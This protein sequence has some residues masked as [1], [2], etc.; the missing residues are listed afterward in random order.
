MRNFSYSLCKQLIPRRSPS[1]AG[2]ITGIVKLRAH[3][4]YYNVL[5]YPCVSFDFRFSLFRMMY[6]ET[7]WCRA[8]P[9]SHTR[10]IAWARSA[11][12]GSRTIRTFSTRRQPHVSADREQASRNTRGVVDCVYMSVY[13]ALSSTFSAPASRIGSIRQLVFWVVPAENINASLYY[14]TDKEIDKGF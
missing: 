1:F 12:L 4:Q 9:H 6:Y 7:S 2:N 8:V 10:S 3:A 11:S 14:L 13:S 5:P